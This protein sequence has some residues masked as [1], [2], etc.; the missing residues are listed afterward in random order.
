MNKY[1]RKYISTLLLI[2]GYSQRD[3]DVPMSALNADDD[4]ARPSHA[5]VTLIAASPPRSRTTRARTS[6]VAG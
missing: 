2:P 4:A 6:S 5:C 1:F 3:R